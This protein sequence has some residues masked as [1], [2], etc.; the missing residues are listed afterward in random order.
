MDERP[1]SAQ[2]DG[3]KFF[4]EKCFYKWKFLNFL[5]E[6]NFR[7]PRPID[8]KRRADNRF[9]RNK[10]PESAVEAVVTIIAH[11]E[12]IIALYC[13]RC[14]LFTVDENLLPSLLNGMALPF[15]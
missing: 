12:D 4:L 15:H 10:S 14:L 3:R 2:P 9:F 8:D 6:R 5:R 11:S 7:V 13:I 1:E